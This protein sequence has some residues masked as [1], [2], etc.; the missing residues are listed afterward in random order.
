MPF[1]LVL[2]AVLAG[3]DELTLL[4][5][6][7][8]GRVVD[9]TGQV[10]TAKTDLARG[11]D[12]ER[13][14]RTGGDALSAQ[15]GGDV[16]GDLGLLAG[17]SKLDPADGLATRPSPDRQV[18]LSSLAPGP[19][20]SSRPRVAVVVAG[21][22]RRGLLDRVAE[23]PCGIGVEVEPAERGSVG[24]PPAVEHEIVVDDD[25]RRLA[26]LPVHEAL[27][28]RGHRPASGKR[29]PEQPAGM[30]RVCHGLAT[31][32]RL[33]ACPTDSSAGRIARLRRAGWR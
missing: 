9:V 24:R 6:P 17:P 28:Y 13:A 4:R 7:P 11:P 16:V 15:F 14:E 27:P 3:E 25:Q 5:D 2:L 31:A 8:G 10:G 12:E 19:E 33:R 29:A 20:V 21:G 22:H 18:E 32:G 30:K 1:E 26:G 23:E